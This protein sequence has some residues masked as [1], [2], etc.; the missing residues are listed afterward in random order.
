M[1]PNAPSPVT[2]KADDDTG[3]ETVEAAVIKHPVQPD[4]AKHYEAKHAAE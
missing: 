3:D 4:V 1:V 2:V